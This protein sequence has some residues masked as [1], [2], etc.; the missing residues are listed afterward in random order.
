MIKWT[1]VTKNYDSMS[2][3]LTTEMTDGRI[4]GIIGR[5]GSGKTTLFR[6]LLGLIFP[7]DGMI[8]INGREAAQLTTREKQKMAVLFSETTTFDSY[9][10]QQ[11]LKFW[12]D[13][14]PNFDQK[15]FLAQAEKFNLLS[16]KPVEKFSKGMKATLKILLTLYTNA[17][18]LILDEPTS[19][20]DVVARDQILTLIQEQFAKMNNGTIL[21][22]S[23]IAS[24]I[25]QICDDIY[26]IDEGKLLLHEE[27]DVI[28][29][30]YGLLK[31][32][33][34]EFSL[35]D[36][37]YLLSVIPTEFGF[38]ALTNQRRYYQENYPQLVTEKGSID[39]VL[40]YLTGGNT[41]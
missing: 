41:Q 22:S 39:D 11:I 31:I 12:P 9:S 1:K 35:L 24:D 10:I 2:F 14:Y 34:N 25:Q 33:A 26:L 29:D 19:G 17:E 8:T 13:F 37:K 18:L 38:T 36:Q 7:E 20:L 16:D 30:Q 3:D 15:L 5:N 28:L 4:T 6:L 23:H 21:I 40:R 27:T 32:P